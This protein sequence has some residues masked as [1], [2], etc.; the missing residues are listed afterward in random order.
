MLCHRERPP[1]MKTDEILSCI[2]I[3]AQ[4]SPSSR[5]KRGMACGHAP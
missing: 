1:S 3:I 4:K 5:K 2:S